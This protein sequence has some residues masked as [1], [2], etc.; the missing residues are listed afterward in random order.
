MNGLLLKD[1]I[2][3]RRTIVMVTVVIVFCMVLFVPWGVSSAEFLVAAAMVLFL[4]VTA[5]TMDTSSR[6]E[7][8][9]L[10]LPLSRREILA[11]RYV[12][13]CLCLGAAAV[14]C[15][16][17]AAGSVVFLG[18]YDLL[19]VSPLIWWAGCTG[20]AL[21]ML[22]LLLAVYFVY[23]VNVGILLFLVLC[24][25]PTAAVYWHD[26]LTPDVFGVIAALL[27]ILGLAGLWVSWRVSLR[28]FE[29]WDV[30]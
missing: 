27:A 9:A 10:S 20:A 3:L 15:G 12:F 14:I 11:A 1:W 19:G 21:L 13:S 26:L 25:V 17:A 2:Y 16:A 6:W 4:P 22:D 24:F 30:T 5:M 29:R 8:Y 28:A 18:G 23:R 7:R